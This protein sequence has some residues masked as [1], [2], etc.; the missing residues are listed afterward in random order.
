MRS[1]KCN[2]LQKCWAPP[3]FLCFASKMG[4][5]EIETCANIHRNPV[6][7]TSHLRNCLCSTVVRFNFRI[8][9]I[10]NKWYLCK[11]HLFHLRSVNT[12]LVTYLSMFCINI[13]Q[14]TGGSGRL[15]TCF[16]SCHYCPCPAFAYSVLRRNDGLVVRLIQ[17]I[18]R[19]ALKVFSWVDVG[20]G[21]GISFKYKCYTNVSVY[22]PMIVLKLKKAKVHFLYYT[23]C[24]KDAFTNQRSAELF[25][26]QYSYK[27][28]GSKIVVFICSAVLWVRAVYVSSF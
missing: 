16:L 21:E 19:V 10:N 4:N 13:F 8:P 23:A 12:N 15:Y 22:L 1:T 5:T 18:C 27:W 25:T 2:A 3:S 6:S 24:D 14:V 17:T 11:W 9:L 20:S 28:W 7:S 26:S